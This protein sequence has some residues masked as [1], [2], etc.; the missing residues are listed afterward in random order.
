MIQWVVERAKRAS[1]ITR[2]LVAT[3][4]RRIYDCIQESGGEVVMTPGG[5]PSGTDRVAHVAKDLDFEII[6]NIQGDEPF[7][8]PEEV[9]QAA[10]ILIENEHA[11]MGTLV[12]KITSIEELENPNTAKVV[13]NEKNDS[14]YFSRSPIPF[15]RNN[16]NMSHWL[17][18]NIYYK[19][20]GIYSYRKQFLLQFASWEPTHLEKSEKLEQLRVLEKGYPIKVAETD[21]EPFC[22][23][24]PEDLERA[25]RLAE[26]MSFSKSCR[27]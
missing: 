16:N 26:Q 6:I 18:N 17:K 3:D 10:R 1:L 20:V 19:H 9:D 21:F 7:I 15:F 4:D 2:V 13:V 25:R 5:I 12:K 27:D 24:T 23:D 11:V 14:L 22:V 8:E